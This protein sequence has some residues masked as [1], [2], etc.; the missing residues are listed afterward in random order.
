MTETLQTFERKKD[1]L[2]C[3]D[4]DGCALNTMEI[5]HQR[6]LG[7][8]TVHVWGLEEYRDEILKL[9]REHSLYGKYRGMNRYQGLEKILQEVQHNFIWIND[10]E[11]L[12]KWAFSSD[13]LSEAGLKAEIART[14]SPMLKKVLV[15]SDLVKGSI[16]MLSDE[17]MPPFE[18]VADAL[19]E[20]SGFADIV[21]VSAAR[22]DELK[23]EWKHYGMTQYV[24][25]LLGQES[26]S[27]EDILRH[28]LEFGYQNEEVLMTGDAPAD[29][30]AADAAEV[31]FY[32]ILVRREKESW[33][34]FRQIVL[35]K[36][37][38]LRYE[39]AYQNEKKRQFHSNLLK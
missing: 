7:P 11:S 15:W 25:L 5:K 24:D 35:P 29:E 6:C 36:F 1:F 2:L 4:S 21:V 9:W 37:I 20:A 13:D 3:I 10:L 26:G 31:L 30:Q 38:E 12:T 17:K 32:P 39:G 14:N 18:G 19:K 34:E 8:C 16:K 23:K 27:K 22:E 28:M 33:R